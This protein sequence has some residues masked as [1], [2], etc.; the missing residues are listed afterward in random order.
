MQ[1]NKFPVFHF[2]GFLVFC[3]TFIY[4][5]YERFLKGEFGNDGN[6]KCDRNVGSPWFIIVAP[7]VILFTSIKMG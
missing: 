5:P 1:K 6:E 7:C 2:F 4:G 3:G